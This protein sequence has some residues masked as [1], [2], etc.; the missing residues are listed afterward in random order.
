MKEA[1]RIFN[2]RSEERKTQFDELKGLFDTAQGDLDS[3]QQ[4]IDTLQGQVDDGDSSKEQDLQDAKDARAALVDA[5]DL[6]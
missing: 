4:E 6:A 1:T 2:E 5:R 3:N